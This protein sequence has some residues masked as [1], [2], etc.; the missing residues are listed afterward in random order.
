MARKPRIHYPGALYHSINR[1]NQ[2]KPIYLSE[3]DF[4]FMLDT[5]AQAATKYGA[6]IHAFCLMTNHFHLLL[7]VQDVP[8]QTI[9][10]S[11]LTAYA[12]HFNRTHNKT[13][14][15]FQGRYRAILCQKE[16]YLLELARYIHLNPLRAHLVEAPQQWRW[17][18]L[19]GYLHPAEHNWLYTKDI[20]DLFGKH[21]RTHL[22]GF[23]SQ[24]S[25]LDP[26]RIYPPESFPILGDEAFVKTASDPV[27]LRR[28]SARSWPGPRFS[29][30]ELSL[31]L[32]Q[33]MHLP[34]HLFNLR[35]KGPK[36][37]S[38]LRASIV[39]AAMQYGFYHNAQL[40]QF[41]HISSS[42]VSILYQNFLKRIESDPSIEASLFQS[43][44][45]EFLNN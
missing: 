5:L 18:S 11:C 43:L 7:Q 40:A 9:M 26:A 14:H 37:L 19:H 12:K 36:G 34:P 32:A 24:A 16:S 44:K 42:A 23:L 45:Q 28:H 3:D 6:L 31:V 1:G 20:L 8:L 35:H 29:L 41:L 10:R 4:L 30:E 25:H 27:A 17:S 2:R 39:Y 15:V 13:G 38:G 33:Q 22:A 21:P